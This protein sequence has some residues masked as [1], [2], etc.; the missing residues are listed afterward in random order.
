MKTQMLCRS[1]P[2]LFRR[3]CLVLLVSASLANAAVAQATLTTLLSFNYQDGGKPQGQALV[4]ATN[5]YLY[6][7]TSAD[8]ANNLGTVFRIT[9]S[10][11]LTTIHNFV[12]TDGAEPNWLIQATNGVFYGTTYLGGAAGAALFL[13]SR[14]TARSRRYTAFA[15]KAGVRMANPKSGWSRPAMAS[16]TGQ[17][18]LAELPAKERCSKSR[19]AA[20]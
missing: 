3:A 12:N 6:G 14:R 7:F 4:Q 17:L 1:L 19:R 11:T 8:G 16:S 20:R 9:T 5:G 2:G 15:P 10:G 18:L 13:D